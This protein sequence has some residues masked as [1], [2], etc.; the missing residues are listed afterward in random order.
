MCNLSGRTHLKTQGGACW[1]VR[2]PSEKQS[3]REWQGKSVRG[4]GH[5]WSQ[6][7]V[8]VKA[9]MEPE[10]S[11]AM[12]R[13][14]D[15]C[16]TLS[17]THTVLSPP[18]SLIQQ[19]RYRWPAGELQVSPTQGAERQ[20]RQRLWP[21]CWSTPTTGPA[22]PQHPVWPAV[23]GPTSPSM[24]SEQ[25]LPFHLPNLTQVFIIAK[26]DP[27]PCKERNAGKSKER[28]SGKCNINGQPLC[29]IP[30]TNIKQLLN[31]NCN[32]K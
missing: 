20:E 21:C 6:E 23:P 15:G 12:R 31:V 2:S 28:N 18:P 17:G 14:W 11:A 1:S 24:E 26:P 16:L 8:R 27:G 7:P 25:P 5:G 30:E 19:G 3:H 29:S 4:L 13:K 10:H 22:D 32:W 9:K